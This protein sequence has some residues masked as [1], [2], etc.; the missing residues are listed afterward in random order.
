MDWRENFQKGKEIIIATC[1]ENMPNAI[2][3]GSLGFVDGKL[4]IKDVQMDATIKNLQANENIC[5]VGGYI[6]LKGEVEIF[7]DGK[8]FDI[9]KQGDGSY[10]P[11]N[12]I[13]VTIKEVFDLDKVKIINE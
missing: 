5:V 2:V 13:L 12:A 9:C 1:N 11:K 8:Y 3:V 6:R 4:L 7:N 10:P